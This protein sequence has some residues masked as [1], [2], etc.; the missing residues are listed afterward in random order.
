MTLFSCVP[1]SDT[2]FAEVLFKYFKGEK[3]PQTLA[4]LK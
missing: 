1:A 2:I 4:L 3:D